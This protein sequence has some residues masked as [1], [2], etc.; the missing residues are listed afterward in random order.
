[1]TLVQTIAEFPHAVILLFK[2]PIYESYESFAR[3]GQV[4]FPE[5]QMCVFECEVLGGF[6]QIHEKS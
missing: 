5:V 3:E 6:F 1:M 4:F 2:L